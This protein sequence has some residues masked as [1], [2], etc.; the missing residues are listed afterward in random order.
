MNELN[1]AD[2]L[3]KLVNEGK[4]ILEKF[5]SINLS[6]LVVDLPEEDP[7]L[8]LATLGILLDR[9]VGIKMS[10]VKKSMA[11]SEKPTEESADLAIL[12]LESK[13]FASRLI[14]KME[15]FMKEGLIKEIK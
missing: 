12:C 1:K 11:S 14:N 7:E 6:D 13:I 4:R 9:I 3:D 2:A 5:G 8:K 15:G 10:E